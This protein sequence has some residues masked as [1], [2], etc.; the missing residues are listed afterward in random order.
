M[1]SRRSVR[2]KVMQLLYAMSRDEELT[3]ND[4][5][6]RYDR[7]VENSFDVFLYNFFNFV[8]VTKIAA[9]D[10]A[11]RKAKHLP[12]EEDKS[13]KA[14]LCEN[15]L[16]SSVRNH[17]SLQILFE[18]KGFATM[19]DKDIYKKIYYEYAKEQSYIDFVKREVTTPESTLETLLDLYRFCRKNELFLELMNDNYVNWIDDDSL[20]IGAVK[21]VL[22]KLPIGLSDDLQMF[23]PDTETVREF[24]EELLRTS[25][26]GESVLMEYISPLLQNWDEDRLAVVDTILLKM[27]TSEFLNF[28]TIPTK[29]TLNEYVEI[30]KAYSTD[31]S[32]E[33]VNGVLD[34][35]MKN[36]EKD[37][38]IQKEGRGLIE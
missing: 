1:L 31:R 19:G 30:S 14:I 8:Q 11:R 13:F 32:K 33:F 35:L 3:Y 23:Y 12:T 18:K 38:K 27:A 29:V 21:K 20:V 16:I 4:I 26:E 9:D 2:I 22:K 10:E 25:V 6:K 24:G 5:R 36:L 15:D 28:E 17:R 37:G 7:A 34:K